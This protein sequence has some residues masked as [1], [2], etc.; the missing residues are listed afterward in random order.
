MV[1]NAIEQRSMNEQISKSQS[2]PSRRVAGACAKADQFGGQRERAW[3]T[4]CDEKPCLN[5]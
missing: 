3:A 5:R 2:D 4:V 1:R